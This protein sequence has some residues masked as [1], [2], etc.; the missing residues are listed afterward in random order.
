M[1]SR[2][3]KS[4]K[5]FLRNFLSVLRTN[6]YHHPAFL[7]STIDPIFL[8]QLFQLLLAD[9]LATILVDRVKYRIKMSR[10]NK[11]KSTFVDL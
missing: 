11:P 6:L 7:S 10:L 1:D 4:N 5:I 3:Q 8:H 9:E 2:R